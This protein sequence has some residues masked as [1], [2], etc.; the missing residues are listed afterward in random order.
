MTSYLKEFK[1]NS[2]ERSCHDQQQLAELVLYPFL[3]LSYVVYLGRHS[4]T[5]EPSTSDLDRVTDSHHELLGSCIQSKEKAKE[6]IFYSYTRYINGF[7][8]ILEDE[9]AAEISKASKSYISFSK[10]NEQITRNKF[11]LSFNANTQP[12]GKFYPLINSVDAKA[13]NVS[14]HQA[15]FCSTGSLDPE[16]VIG[17]VVYCT[18]NEPLNIVEKSFVVAQAGGVGVV[19]ANQLI[20]HQISPQAH[21]VPTS[22]VSAV[23]GLSMLS[24]IYSSKSPVAY[25][26]GA[27]EVGTV[28][29]DSSPGPNSIT[30]EILK[31]DITAPGMHILAAF[32]EASGP[33][34]LPG[35][36]R[37]VP[38][39]IM[40]GSSMACPNVSGIAGLLRT[41][42]PDWSPAAINNARQPIANASLLEA[43]PL[44]YDAGHVWPSRAMEP[45][46]VYDLTTK[47]YVNF[48]C[49]IGYNSIEV[50]LFIGEQYACQSHNNS[51]LDFNYPSI[52]VPDISGKITLSRTLKNVGTPS[53]YRVHIDAPKGIS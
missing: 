23:D 31:P 5:S 21:V 10:P 29:F 4:H 40:Y 16:K 27:T 12:A 13:A 52:T 22:F 3:D 42:H 46:L 47:D 24:Y 11:G 34:D 9:A 7:A 26:S 2:F 25:I 15:K 33:T 8:A 49:F 37:R 35:D 39:N 6:A 38:F 44:N 32:T 14:S 53:L 50:S 1:F 41:I 20:T 43:N 19:L 17:K 45:G 30:P 18:R 48:L 28:A 36:R 51:L